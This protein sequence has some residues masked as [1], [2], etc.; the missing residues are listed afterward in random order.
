[1][2]QIKDQPEN[3]GRWFG[4]CDR[5]DQ[6]GCGYWRWLDGSPRYF[7]GDITWL[8]DDL[9]PLNPR[10]ATFIDIT[11][12]DMRSW[13]AAYDAVEFSETDYSEPEEELESD[14]SEDTGRDFSADEASD[15]QQRPLELSKSDHHIVS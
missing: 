5:D 14:E 13:D 1:M 15:A 2:L 9:E 3:V 6:D 12:E 10:D 4:R 11:E 7:G 8:G